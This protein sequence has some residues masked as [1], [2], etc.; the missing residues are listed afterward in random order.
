PSWMEHPMK[1]FF[2]Y[3][4]L[5][6]LSLTSF[7]CAKADPAEEAV[8]TFEKLAG[9][10]EANSADCDKLAS[11]VDSFVADNGDELNRLKELDKGLT[12][13]QKKELDAKYEPR[14][15]AAFSKMR[16]SMAKCGSNEKVKASF[17]KLKL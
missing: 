3:G 6:A 4:L 16:A 10:V 5:A 15:E 13:E 11:A 8:A 17:D 9:V 7:A 12:P 14:M 2:A 1:R